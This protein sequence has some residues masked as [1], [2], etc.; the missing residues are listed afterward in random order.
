MS[1]RYEK[2]EKRLLRL[3]E[4]MRQRSRWSGRD[5]WT[6]A[7]ARTPADIVKEARR[8]GSKPKGNEPVLS[9]SD[10]FHLLREQARSASA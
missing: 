5:P 4:E 6:R 7:D 10:I 8:L 9:P 3:A 2:K 1:S